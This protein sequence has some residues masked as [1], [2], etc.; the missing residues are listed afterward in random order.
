MYYSFP[1]E[2]KNSKAVQPD[3][4][5]FVID[6]FNARHVRISLNKANPA[7]AGQFQEKIEQNQLTY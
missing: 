2:Y 6:E 3:Y 7:D 4:I 1:L 5:N